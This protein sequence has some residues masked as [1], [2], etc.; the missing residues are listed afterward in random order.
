MQHARLAG[1]RVVQFPE[2]TLAYAGPDPLDWDRAAWP[3]LRAQ[4]D[5]IAADARELGLWVV[6]GAPHRLT[7]SRRP[8]NSLYVVS[9]T[10]D[11]VTRYDKRF[12]SNTEITNLYT[13]GTE[14]T[15]VDIDGTRIGLA[16]CIEAKFPEVFAEYE[17]HNADAVLLSAATTDPIF[18]TVAQAHAELFS[19]WIGFAAPASITGAASPV[20]SNAA[21]AFTSNS[22]SAT[23]PRAGLI[24]PGGRWLAQ[25]ARVRG[26]RGLAVA[27]IDLGSISSDIDTSRRLARPWRRT[28]RSG[29][30]AP[31]TA[32]GDP[33][34]KNRGEF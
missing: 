15:I 6:F 32:K 1:A 28:A 4:A 26:R 19:M 24:A 25:T 9:D 11:L 10:G 12:L 2:G 34:S 29:L 8:H 22:G 16:I 13:P 18:A 31:H 21:S 7:G 23:A 17:R 20:A 3:E 30:Y 27:D 5:A 14:A 33:R